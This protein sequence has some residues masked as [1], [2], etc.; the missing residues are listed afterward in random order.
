MEVTAAAG[1]T[2]AGAASGTACID[3]A[4]ETTGA[5]AMEIDAGDTIGIAI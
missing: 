3:V 2:E 1:I 4:E 5:V